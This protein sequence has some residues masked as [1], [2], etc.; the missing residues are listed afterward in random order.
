[1]SAGSS[2]RCYS[3]RE[4]RMRFSPQ[5]EFF[6]MRAGQ[7]AAFRKVDV[8]QARPRNMFPACIPFV[9][10]GERSQHL[11]A[12]P[13]GLISTCQGMIVYRMGP[14]SFILPNTNLEDPQLTSPTTHL[15]P[16]RDPKKAA[17]MH[18]LSLLAVAPLALSA[19]I[20]EARADQD[21]IPGKFIV[22]MKSDASESLFASTISSV[23]S[24]LGAA[25]ERT[26][27]FGNFKAFS[28]SADNLLLNSISALGAIEFIEPDSKVYAN[29]LV[30][31]ANPPYGLARISHRTK[32]A[33]A[34]VYDDSAGS[35]TFSYIIDTGIYTSHND[36]GGRAV[37][38]SNFA[39]DGKDTDCNGHG[40]HVAGTTGSSTYGVA[41][42]TN[43][44]AVKVLGCDGSGSNSGVLAGIDWAVRDAKAKGRVGKA[45][46]NLSL[47]GL[48]SPTT[49]QAAAQAI[50]QGLFLAIAAG[51]NGLPT[52][53][54]SPASEPSACTVGA[55]DINDARAS[56][57]NFGYLVDIFAPGVNVT[58]TWI[59][60]P[61]DTN[62]ISGTSM[63]TPHI[64]GLGAYLLALEGPRTPAA[65]CSR[66]QAL[67]T[68][69]VIS[70]PGLLSKNY[71]AYNGAA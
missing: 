36:F 31:Q 9:S 8:H 46:G 14:T 62:T 57:S 29:A 63:A 7:L 65:L 3:P 21:V 52:I 5:L 10:T 55:T 51:N 40:T 6:S 27:N 47:G 1:M 28:I 20:L 61:D 49:N 23:T 71:L 13:A 32:G 41:K 34:Y 12:Y 67:A 59:G 22:K 56:F 54:S 4:T 35:G 53:T 11:P 2:S 48:F 58:S 43:L 19:P 60:G 18:V 44:I 39:G 70:N 26:F 15:F 38:G 33:S 68:K 45:V 64:T 17:S 37:F 16:V 50:S 25:P 42:K 24:I 66:I 30:S 69:G